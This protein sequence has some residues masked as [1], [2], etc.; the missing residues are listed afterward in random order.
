[1]LGDIQ[2]Y[3]VRKMDGV[4]LEGMRISVEFAKEAPSRGPR[5]GGGGGVCCVSCVRERIERKGLSLSFSI[6]RSLS[7]S[8]PLPLCLS[9]SLSLS[10]FLYLSLSLYVYR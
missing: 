2:E 4:N 1:V 6:S 8:F 9:V 3:A 5:P 7:L 10:P